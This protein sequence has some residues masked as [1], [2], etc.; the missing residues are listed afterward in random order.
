MK[1]ESI[2]FAQYILLAEDERERYE[3]AL[4][5][6]EEAKARDV[7]E[8]GDITKKTFGTVKDLQTI[9][10]KE[11]N[12]VGFV[13]YCGDIRLKELNV[14]DFVANYKYVLSEVERVS[15]I[16]SKILGH[17]PTSD[18]FSAGLERFN[19]YGVFIQIDTLAGGDP[20]KYAGIKD[21]PYES[22]LAKLSYEKD[23]SDYQRDYMNIINRRNNG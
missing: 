10:S 5:Y 1:I 7:L 19:K 9:F 22:M 2:N 12:F 8:F 4:R 17:E 6:S 20:I 23:K 16:E 3:W 11:N 21:L 18:E 14:F 13:D 15:L